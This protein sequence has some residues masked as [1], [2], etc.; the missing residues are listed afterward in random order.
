MY[1]SGLSLWWR[2]MNQSRSTLA[3]T[4]DHIRLHL[5]QAVDSSALGTLEGAF[6]LLHLIPLVH[7]KSVL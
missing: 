2:L 7:M 1:R 6:M 5:R 4:I 3:A